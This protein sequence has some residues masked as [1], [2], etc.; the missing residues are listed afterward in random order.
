ML[1][2]ALV[3]RKRFERLEKVDPY[4]E[5]DLANENGGLPNED[6]WGNISG[7]WSFWNIFMI[8]HYEFQALYMWLLILFFMILSDVVVEFMD[9]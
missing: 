7:M 3:L 2:T 8:S 5:M 1:D 6:N 4:Y 9:R